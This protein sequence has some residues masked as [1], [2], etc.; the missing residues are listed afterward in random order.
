MAL[1]LLALCCLSS[2]S[3]AGGFFGGFIP[4]TGPHFKKVSGINDVLK[5]KTF[6]NDYYEKA[7]GKKN[8]KER[9]LIIDEFRK[10]NPDEVTSFCDI[11]KKAQKNRN[12]PP[13][14]TVREVLTLGGMKHTHVV[15]TEA[16]QSIGP[17]A[18]YL[19]VAAN[20]FCQK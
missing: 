14:D 4:R 1:I 6:L 20:A 11:A 9:K 17:G 19:E 12:T 16:L 10:S 18:Q 5:L 15:S 2:S 3:V 8:E 7:S 13:Y